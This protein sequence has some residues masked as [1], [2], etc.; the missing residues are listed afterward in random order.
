MADTER[1]LRVFL[2]HAKAD[3]PTAR[4][5]Y[6]KL[7][8]EGWIDVW[9]DEEKLFP[10]Q[11]WDIEI[12][13]AVEQT[14]V[15]VVCLSTGSADKEG[16]IQKELRFVLSIAEEKP[17]GT[18]FVTPLRLDDCDIPRRLRKWQ[19]ADY[20][21]EEERGRAYERL[22]VSLRMRADTLD[23]PIVHQHEKRFHLEADEKSRRDWEAGGQKSDAG[24]NKQEDD[25]ARKR[26]DTFIKPSKIKIF[27][28]YKRN[29]EPDT[30]V[31][32]AVYEA[33]RN[34]HDVFIDT[35]L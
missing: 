18:I 6:R 23:I 4:E 5:L 20:F 19:C 11:E 13:K 17:E 8:A 21:P 30:P 9:L 31:A 14:D 26:L 35:T 3:K 10:G 22:L 12:E 32:E 33:L 28:S 25:R 1:P 24:S 34:D 2:C 7:S 15:V 27:I 16:Y 29:V